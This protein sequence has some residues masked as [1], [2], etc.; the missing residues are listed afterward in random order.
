MACPSVSR[1]S[2]T[3]PADHS[4]NHRIAQMFPGTT[5]PTVRRCAQKGHLLPRLIGAF[6]VA[7]LALSDR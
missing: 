2:R 4:V 3:V 6:N 5:G 1:C 7:V